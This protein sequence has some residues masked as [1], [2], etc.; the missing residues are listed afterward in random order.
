MSYLFNKGSVGSTPTTAHARKNL[1]SVAFTFSSMTAFIS[2]ASSIESPREVDA[3]ASAVVILAE[4]STHIDAAISGH[5]RV[6][7]MQQVVGKNGDS[8][9]LVF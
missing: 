6:L 1:Q 7:S 5:S 9:A 2:A 3:N 8:E 4:L